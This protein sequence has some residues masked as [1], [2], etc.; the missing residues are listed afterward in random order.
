MASEDLRT[1]FSENNCDYATMVLKEAKKI[2]NQKKINW[3]QGL[4]CLKEQIQEIR[5]ELSQ[6]ANK[7]KPQENYEMACE[8]IEFLTSLIPR[9]RKK[10]PD[11]VRASFLSILLLIPMEKRPKLSL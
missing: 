11:K 8:L 3:K 1:I 7:G 10:T 2:L 5:Q 6:P 9:S 4:Q